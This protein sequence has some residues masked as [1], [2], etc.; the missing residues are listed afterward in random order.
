M[1][2]QHDGMHR[3]RGDAFTQLVTEAPRLGGAIRYRNEETQNLLGNNFG[4]SN[5]AGTLRRADS[6]KRGE[7]VSEQVLSDGII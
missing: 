2:D 4:I 1:R 7:V 5:V 6:Q 3:W